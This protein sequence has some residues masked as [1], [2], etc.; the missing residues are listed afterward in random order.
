MLVSSTSVVPEILEKGL[1]EEPG[2]S[3]ENEV[4]LKSSI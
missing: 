2:E 3:F 1:E 4:N